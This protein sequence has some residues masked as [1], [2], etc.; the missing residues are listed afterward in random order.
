[1]RSDLWS[2]LNI[3]ALNINLLITKK[4]MSEIK[5]CYEFKKGE[6]MQITSRPWQPQDL[7]DD[8]QEIINEESDTYLNSK[9]STLCM[10]RD[11]LKNYF[12]AEMEQRLF[13]LPPPL[14]TNDI[15][16]IENIGRILLNLDYM[17]KIGKE[18]RAVW[19]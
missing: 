3:L 2:S 7:I 9:K 14:T 4:Q 6:Q 1:M 13:V 5:V 10:A 19:E 8:L 15:E 11:Y 18:N 16:S 17:D 12:K